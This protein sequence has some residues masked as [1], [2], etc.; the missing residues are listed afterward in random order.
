MA[1]LHGGQVGQAPDQPGRIC[2]VSPARSAERGM[3]RIGSSLAWAMGNLGQVRIPRLGG[4]EASEAPDGE[5][6]FSLSH[7][8]RS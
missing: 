6:P 7:R 1:G 2:Q 8:G 5:T 4:E 3:V